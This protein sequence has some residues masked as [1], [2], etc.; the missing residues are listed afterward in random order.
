MD[1]K[2]KLVD[3]KKKAVLLLGVVLVFIAAVLPACSRAASTFGFGGTSESIIH[4][5]PPTKS[6]GLRREE[7]L[8]DNVVAPRGDAWKSEL[9]TI[10]SSSEAFAEWDLGKPTP[11]AAIYL[12]GDD[13]DTYSVSM[14]DDGT[15]FRPLWD[16]RPVGG[17]GLQPRST[18][19]L[20]ATARFIRVNATGGDGSF[21][22]AEIQV[23]S[24]K[25]GTWPPRPVVKDSIPPDEVLR[26]KILALGLALALFV[27]FTW[28]GAP[29]WWT[30][31]VM[32]VPC[33]AGFDAWRALSVAWPP[34]T[35]EVALVRG[36]VAAVGALLV[37]REVFAPAKLLANR[38]VSVGVL[39]VCAALAIGAFYNLG[40]PQ[41]HDYQNGRPGFVHNFDMRVYFPIAK[42]FKELRFDGLYL[43][44]VAAYVDDDKSVTLDSLRT[45]QLR[46]L[47]THRMQSV[48]ESVADIQEVRSRF[49]PARW[50]DFKRDMRYFRE[51][52]GVRDYLGSMSDHGGNATPVWFMFGH[53]LFRSAWASNQTL[54]ITAM[55][56]PI[57]LIV[58]LGMI[59]RAFGVRT[60]L[61][62]AIIFGA[63][64]FYMF[65]T[66]WAG[67]TLRHDWLAYLA[68]GIAALKLNRWILA[69]ALLMLSGMIR[70]FPFFALV[71]VALPTLWWLI[72]HVRTTK[73]LPSIALIKSE[74]MPFLKIVLGALVTGIVLFA[75][76]SAMF[77][78]RSWPEWLHKVSMLQR[79]PHVNHVSLRAL[80]GGPDGIHTRVML[81]RTNLFVAGIAAF[82]VMVLIAGRRK[83]L[84]FAATLGTLMI[85]VVFHPANYY[86][87]FI[88]VLPML[89]TELRDTKKGGELWPLKA[90]DGG[91]WIA[92][93]GLCAAQYFVAIEKDLGLHFYYS[94]ALIVLGVATLL[95]LILSRDFGLAAQLVPAPAAAGGE[96]L[97]DS[98]STAPLA[99]PADGDTTSE[100]SVAAESEPEPRAPAV[101]PEPS[102]AAPL[103]QAQSAPA[104]ESEASD[105]D[106]SSP[107]AEV[108]PP[109]DEPGASS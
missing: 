101:E 55:L 72:D 96:G 23:F 102:A 80:I 90:A 91:L 57:L 8:T 50:E 5:K 68:M 1:G 49:S 69:G 32:L 38:R 77:G 64:D 27:V 9:T 39:G 84:A 4:G 82:S 74:Q 56:D 34:S 16:G 83:N 43:G 104:S 11:I 26:N 107:T 63:N 37:V 67:A 79:D 88:F 17:G 58:A 76:S 13:N 73:R 28:K 45:Q 10:F 98:I 18:D 25:P 44:S 93:L 15:T 12:L 108:K 48:G 47:R 51:N 87:H 59:W 30:L 85:P 6:S 89:A 53:A 35:R 60:A 33:V 14:S 19:D 105:A 46:S 62:C 70:A 21:A 7:R 95:L 66:C 97:M 103:E 71:G 54:T 99:E 2:R 40:H 22:L 61:V 36:V 86:I 78:L 106:T 75:A 52:M 41:F 20:Q 109:A 92:L 65:G 3:V 29:F 42:Y 24:E 31:L 94:S 81:A 100:V